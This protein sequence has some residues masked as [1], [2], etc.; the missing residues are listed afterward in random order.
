MA[1][2]N[3]FAALVAASRCGQEASLRSPYAGREAYTTGV[4]YQQELSYALAAA[5]SVAVMLR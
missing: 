3:G 1:M 4:D 2:A 5:E